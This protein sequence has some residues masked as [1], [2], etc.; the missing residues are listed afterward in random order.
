MDL[1]RHRQ[2]LILLGCGLLLACRE[3][4]R[5]VPLEVEYAGCSEV[6]RDGPVCLVEAGDDPSA[7]RLTLWTRSAA[8]HAETKVHLDGRSSSFRSEPV[9]EGDRIVVEVPLRTTLVE[10]RRTTAAEEARWSLRLR[11]RQD[12][13]DWLDRAYRLSVSGESANAQQARTLIETNLAAAPP[14]TRGRALSVLARLP[15]D[16]P[17]EERVL[18]A[19]AAR[20]SAGQLYGEVYDATLLARR[21]AERFDLAAAER[22]LGEV[23]LP[24]ATPA[25]ALVLMEHTR[26]VVA[27]RAGDMRAALRSIR[28]AAARAERLGLVG[29]RSLVEH[30][31]ALL[32]LD[33]GR[34]AEADEAL[35]R[36]DEPGPPADACERQNRADNRA[37]VRLLAREAGGD[38]GDPLPL[39][40]A[41]RE[42]AR[43]G[44]CPER[45]REPNAA[46]NLALAYLQT[47][48]V[49]A[50]ATELATAARLA[51]DATAEERLWLRELE[52][53]LALARDDTARAAQRYDE[54]AADARAAGALEELWRA[55]I[56]LAATRAAADPGRVENREGAL[57][58]L[59]EAEDLVDREALLVPW[60]GRSRFAAQWLR[61]AELRIELLLAAGRTGDALRAARRSRAR[62]A[63]QL[64]VETRIDLLH[65]AERQRFLD[66]AGRYRQAL[67]RCADEAAQEWR[68]AGDRVHQQRSARVQRCAAA[69]QELEGEIGA[70]E[71]TE[72]LDPDPEAF[73]PLR[74]GE[75]VLA[76]HPLR[77]G[78]VAWA[79]DESGVVARRFE[80]PS[81]TPPPAQLAATLLEP[82][83]ER[84]RRARRLRVLALGPLESVDFHA[85]PFGGAPLIATVPVVYGLDLAAP[86]VRDH[87]RAKRALVVADPR[88]DLPAA[89][90][91]G[92]AVR[93]QLSRQGWRVLELAGRDATIDRWFATLADTDLLHFA[94]HAVAGNAEQGGELLL[95]AKARLS[96]TEI[97][98]LSS[99]PPWVVLAGC[100]ASAGDRGS[101]LPGLAVAPAF[102]LR[103]ARQVIA[104]VRPVPDRETATLFAGLYGD[105]EETP[106]LALVLQRAQISALKKGNAAAA[107][108]R[109]YE[110]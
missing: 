10:L 17:Q 14:T 98:A 66:A 88:G 97:L 80:L 6:L 83:G 65:G 42:L 102:L 47:G 105:L 103:G 48:R 108:F 69:Q 90:R 55:Q 110:P 87:G 38:A 104:A 63:R 23:D 20:R 67:Q 64:E 40:L 60:P 15:L 34:F 78:W 91:E 44:A 1:A 7:V 70:L 57:A 9:G 11:A 100:E 107:N 109:V 21:Q 12:W 37:W 27:R 59:R 5:V 62:V 13:P 24:A 79:A 73:P 2:Q 85:L 8:A 41:A 46:L 75:L 16:E 71:G 56:G 51:S 54:L 89:R 18:R 30:Q 52:A 49:D 86:P 61:G 84:I 4:P 28:S 33:L 36:L 81:I 22:T 101:P 19:L 72:R 26:A 95:A 68:L 77:Q 45:H 31:H 32:L 96:G 35:A 53:R 99:A 39:A 92:D 25:E 50:A 94:G 82:F 3:Q 29:S 58:A 76:F 43:S 93:S 74:P 106:D